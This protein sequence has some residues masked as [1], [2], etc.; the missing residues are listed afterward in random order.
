MYKI[1]SGYVEFEIKGTYKT[2]LGKEKDFLG[3][4]QVYIEPMLVESKDC[5]TQIDILHHK[6]MKD[7]EDDLK[8]K[9][10]L[11][12][13]EYESYSKIY[14]NITKYKYIGLRTSADVKDISEL[15]VKKLIDVVGIK[16]FVEIENYY[17]NN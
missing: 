10:Y 16:E 1:I 13:Y 17:R 15:T 5:D 11:H 4:K 3:T 12:S 8:H 2:W 7:I 14:K 9:H 6:I